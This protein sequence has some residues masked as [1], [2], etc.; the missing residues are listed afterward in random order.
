MVDIGRQTGLWLLLDKSCISYFE[1]LAVRSEA[2][3]DNVASQK[4]F[5]ES[6]ISKRVRAQGNEGLIVA[7][8]KP[9]AGDGGELSSP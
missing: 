7:E 1:S 5:W 8:A 4:L 6:A 9:R 3:P 2:Q